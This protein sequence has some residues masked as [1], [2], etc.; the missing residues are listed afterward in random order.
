MNLNDK[1]IKELYKAHAEQNAPDMDAL[2][3]RIERGLDEKNTDTVSGVTSKACKETYRS[4]ED[5][6][7]CGVGCG[8]R[9]GDSSRGVQGNEQFQYGLRFGKQYNERGM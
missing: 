5:S 7:T 2:W 6:R 8:Y 3:E 9:F 1:K 4:W